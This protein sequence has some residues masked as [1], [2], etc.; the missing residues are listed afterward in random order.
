MANKKI[1]NERRKELEQIDPFQQTLLDAA[2]W[3]KK[4]KAQLFLAAA[5]IVIIAVVTAGIMISFQKSETNAALLLNKALMH[6]SNV[7]ADDPK[8]AYAAVENE[9]KTIFSDYSNTEA[10][11]RAALKFARICYDASMFDKSHRYYE[12]AF[13][14]FKS[15]PLMKNLILAALGRVCLAEKDME[16]AAEYFLAID[17]GTTPLLKDEAEFNM[18][19]LYEKEGKLEKSRKLYEKIVMNHADSM[20]MPIADVRKDE[21]K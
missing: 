11:R 14:A 8:K 13:G 10:G 15:D 4:Y 17:N 6:Y 1:S 19:I 16:K 21:V 9:F 7:K 5:G 12:K 18:A 2:A 3:A 20:Y